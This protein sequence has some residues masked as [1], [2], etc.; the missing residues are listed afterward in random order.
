MGVSGSGKTT[1]GKKLAAEIKFPFFDGDDFHSKA[2]KE[3]MKAGHPLTDDDRA[4]WLKS[5]NE[6]AKDQMQKN[7]AV[8][9]CS[10]LKEKYRNILSTGITAPLFWIFL[11]G[12]FDQ[13]KKRM[14]ERKGHFMQ[15]QMLSSQ[16]NTLE[17]PENA[18]TTD[19]SKSPDEIVEEIISAIKKN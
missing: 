6:F 10:A 11:Q 8:I 2:N 19:I 7:G 9:A 1:I 14:E 17:I 5:I 18:I 13:I 16:F 3:K 4:E 12:S 15:P